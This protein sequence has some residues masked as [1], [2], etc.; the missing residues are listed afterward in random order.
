MVRSGTNH[1][2]I[3]VGWDDNFDK[4]KFSTIK[5]ASNGAWLVKNSWGTGFGASGYFWLSYEDATLNR[6]NSQAFVFDFESAE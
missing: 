2:I 1:A 5:P 3:I 6:A 4:A